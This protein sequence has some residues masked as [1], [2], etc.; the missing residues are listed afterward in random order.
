MIKIAIVDDESL[1]RVG[2]QTIIDWQAE[3]Y[4]LQGVYRNGKEAWEAFSIE[5]YPE[6]LLTDIRMPEMDGLELI[7]RI[8]ETD[9]EMIILILSSFEEFEYTRKSIQLGVHDYIPKHLFDPEELISTLTRLCTNTRFTSKERALQSRA[10]AMD[11]ERQKLM[12]KSR[13]LPG[14]L[15]SDVD[16]SLEAYPLLSDILK[17]AASVCW[18]TVRI[19]LTDNSEDDSDQTALGFLLQ[20][21]MNKTV[22]A[23]PLG[24]DQGIF[25]G[26][27]FSQ[28][29]GP[30]E[31]I[32][33]AGLV[34]EWME[35]IKQNLAVTVVA[36]MSEPRG[37][38][39]GKR[40]RS[41]SEQMLDR[42]FFK[43]PGLYRFESGPNDAPERL[44]I[45]LQKWQQQFMILMKNAS[46]DELV[47]WLD[48]LGDELS[49]RDS[50]DS[51]FRLFQRLFKIY[52]ND[53]LD[54]IAMK[55]AKINLPM[56]LFS[57]LSD[58]FI[59]T[60]EELK[61]VFLQAIEDLDND[62]KTKL[63]SQ[64][65]LESAFQY[66][67]EHYAEGIRLE[68]VAGVVKL[69]THYF[70]H[71]FSQE[72]GMTF[73]E[74]VTQ[75]RIRVSMELMK[76]HQLSAEEVA[77]RVGYPNSNYFV[78]VF[79]KVTGMTVSEF[80]NSTGFSTK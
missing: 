2:F 18:V 8:R 15:S 53:L 38:Q 40:L 51:A 68:D 21:L 48:A 55:D 52:Q 32:M 19:W 63:K 24:F 29:H 34:K 1:V 42:S 71:R 45:R 25:H 49:R 39:Q 35:T 80:R 22:H 59:R 66:V 31:V 12:M 47:K 69:N 23:V 70:S 77:S 44:D 26:L 17:D 72:M 75:V 50:P 79:K 16:L 7:R 9:K 6:V 58:G 11:E 62:Y 30:E 74:Y 54:M 67:E 37:F 28:E 3:G 5:G 46:Q 64:P 33:M 27:L 73:L 57:T 13:F 14:I 20:D 76:R 36:G 65:W 78:K 60:W 56:K 10:N 4:E 61:S 41:Q 43:G